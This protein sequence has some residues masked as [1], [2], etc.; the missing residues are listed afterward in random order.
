MISLVVVVIDV[1][2]HSPTEV[3]LPDRD[4]LAQT[5]RLDGSHE[6]LC[7]RIEIRTSSRKFHRMDACTLERR[8]EGSSEQRIAIMKQISKVQKESVI[9]IGK[10]P[11]NLAHPGAIG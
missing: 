5:F 1:L 2:A 3:A 6:S 8:L 9:V 10:V 7:V 11:G 4:D